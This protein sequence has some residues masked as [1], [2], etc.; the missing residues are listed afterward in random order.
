MSVFVFMYFKSSTFLESIAVSFLVTC[1]IFVVSALLLGGFSGGENLPALGFCL[2]LFFIL[3]LLPLLTI[4]QSPLL[5]SSDERSELEAGRGRLSGLMLDCGGDGGE[6]VGIL[7]EVVFV[8]SVIAGGVGDCGFLVVAT[9]FF[10]SGVDVVLCV[11][12][13]VCVVDF[14][15]FWELVW[16]ALL[17]WVLVWA[18]VLLSFRRHS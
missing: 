7:C 4:C 2:G 10:D 5:S 1:V 18:E 11:G 13:T 9:V 17:V 8:V 3:F 15:L 12:V 16:C 6:D 14:F